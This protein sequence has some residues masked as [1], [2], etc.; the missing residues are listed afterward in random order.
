MSNN[1]KPSLFG[2]KHSSRDYSKAD[3]WGKNQFNSSF[4]A[5]LIA[6]M[7]SK[8]LKPIYIK[9]TKENIIKHE[10]IDCKDL[11]GID[12][13]SDDAY[14]NFEAGY[15][16]YEKFYQGDRE[17]IDLVMLNNK[18]NDVLS[19]LEV[20]LT[21]LPDNTTKKLDESKWGCEIVM[22]PPTINFLACSICSNYNSLEGKNQ[23]RKLL[24]NVPQIN[25]W[26]EIEEVLEHY[27]A[28]EESILAVSTDMCDKQKPLILQ[29]IWKT[30]GNRMVLK[31]D[32]LDA[33]IWSDLSII[34]MC[35]TGDTSNVVR[36]NR[37]NRT[38]IWLYKMLL[39]FVTYDTFDYKRIIR[40]QSYNLANDKAF[41]LP[42]NKSH[43]FL[44]GNEIL[45]PRISKYEIKNI[46]LGGGQNLL[47]PER[48][49]DAVLV[50]SPEIF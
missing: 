41:S 16:P 20:K 28:I 34:Q 9:T 7:H 40:L 19:G 31:D 38:I 47:S 46:I 29:P 35:K 36:I 44:A 8:G 39:D 14:Y 17:K 32:C 42:G 37:F 50:Y 2:Q 49:F 6:Y 22:R 10:Y 27:Q 30:E 21:A 45:K 18:T 12:P 3:C 33:F 24:K 26:E 25:H 1:I 48:R 5:S 13:L 4:P 11:F 43:V 15:S 23:L